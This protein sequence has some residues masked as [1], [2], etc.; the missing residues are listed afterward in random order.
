M[1]A[2]KIQMAINEAKNQSS[3][4]LK[5]VLDDKSYC[6][7]AR[8]FDIDNELDG[9]L[10]SEILVKMPLKTFSDLPVVIRYGINVPSFSVEPIGAILWVL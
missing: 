3:S 4:K 2:N 7:L 6:R 9:Y 1:L 5:L 8:V 10:D